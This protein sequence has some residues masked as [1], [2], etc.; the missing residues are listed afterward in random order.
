MLVRT[1]ACLFPTRAEETQSTVRYI[2]S[3]GNCSPTWR[4]WVAVTETQAWCAEKEASFHIL[5]INFLTLCS[6]CLFPCLYLAWFVQLW[7]PNPVLPLLILSHFGA[8]W[9]FKDSWI[10]KRKTF[11]I[12]DLIILLPLSPSL[13]THSLQ[14]EK[15]TCIFEHFEDQKGQINATLKMK[16]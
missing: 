2:L 15:K 4:E 13:Q 16:H 14:L 3:P 7:I 5:W 10:R 11:V 12:G 8:G 9:S 6:C 1:E